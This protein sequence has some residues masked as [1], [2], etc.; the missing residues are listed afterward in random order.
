MVTRKKNQTTTLSG[1]Q[2]LH[3]LRGWSLGVNTEYEHGHIGYPF[4]DAAHRRQLWLENREFFLSLK[5][6]QRIPGVFGGSLK[7]G[8]KPAAQKDYEK[9]KRKSKPI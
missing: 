2:T 6:G 8:E 1:Q 7:K 9:P 5:P 3:L 4:R